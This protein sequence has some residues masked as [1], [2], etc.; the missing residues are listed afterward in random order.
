[1]YGAIEWP[2][3]WEA[4]RKQYQEADG[5]VSWVHH[6]AEVIELHGDG[7]AFADRDAGQGDVFGGT[8]AYSSSANRW[9]TTERE[10]AH[11]QGVVAQGLPTSGTSTTDDGQGFVVPERAEQWHRSVDQAI[12]S[13][14][15]LRETGAKCKIV[16]MIC[17][18]SRRAQPST[19]AHRGDGCSG[20]QAMALLVR[21]PCSQRRGGSITTNCTEKPTARH[22][23][24]AGCRPRRRRASRS[25]AGIWRAQAAERSG[26][27]HRC[28]RCQGLAEQSER[29]RRLRQGQSIA[30]TV[31]RRLQSRVT[32]GNLE[33]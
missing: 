28:V 17:P 29:K 1:M 24:R 22:S 20:Q 14:G 9:K 2:K 8:K 27:H 6:E 16:A 12:A 23:S 4:V 31:M 13:F 19:P 10:C 25:D 5:W 7:T 26:S 18:A 11:P 3:I 33:A 32:M 30:G 15:G 21:K